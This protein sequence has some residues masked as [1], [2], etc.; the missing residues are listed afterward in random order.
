M[1]RI[2]PFYG[3]YLIMIVFKIDF[4]CLKSPLVTNIFDFFGFRKHSKI[5]SF[6]PLWFKLFYFTCN[7]NS[8]FEIFD[9][10]LKVKSGNSVT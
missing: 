6:A 9:E 4:G 10:I 8:K 7:G 1:M 3:S 2:V 5:H